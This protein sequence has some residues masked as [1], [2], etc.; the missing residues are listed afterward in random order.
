MSVFNISREDDSF[1]YPP[2]EARTIGAQLAQDYRDAHPY[3]HIELDDFFPEKVLDQ[4]LLDFPRERA[5][6]VTSYDKGYVGGKAK[7]QFNPTYLHSAYIKD[8]FYFFNSEAFIEFLEGLTGIDGLIPDPFFEGA[9]LHEI[10]TGGKLGIHADF[11]IQRRLSLQRRVN[12]LIYLN[13]NWNPEWGG[14]LELWDKKMTAKVKAIQPVFNRCV[15]FN[16]DA[17]S[18]HGHPDALKTPDSV[19]RKSIA[20]Y[21]YTASKAV[22]TEVEDNSTDYRVRPGD[23]LEIIGEKALQNIKNSVRQIAPPILF[24]IFKSKK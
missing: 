12:V 21:Y 14:G 5:A 6:G 11:R 23:G 2:S 19:T 17:D 4:V 24:N 7:L 20:L 3:P 9:G 16:T 1:F 8:L 15:V 22:F 18:F 13:R 10:S